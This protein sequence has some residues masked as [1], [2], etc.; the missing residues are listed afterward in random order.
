MLT[1]LGRADV[2]RLWVVFGVTAVFGVAAPV[3]AQQPAVETGSK[4]VLTNAAAI[5]E[6]SSEAAARHL[7]VRLCGVVLGI[8][9][10]G[11]DGYAIH[12]GTAGIY[13]QGPR[14]QVATLGH[15][16]L[17][18]V[19]GYTDPGEFAPFV[20]QESV[21]RLG[22]GE[23][24]EPARASFD[25]IISGRTD[26]Q[27]IEVTGV[28]RY[29]EPNPA[30]TNTCRLELT[31]GG[32]RLI[33]RLNVPEV[34]EPLVDAQVR[35]RGVCYYQVNKH[36]QVINAVLSVPREVPIIIEEPAP[37]DPFARPVQPINTLLQ[38][39][40]GGSYGH[41]VHVTGVV[42]CVHP[43]EFWIRDH[44][45]GLRVH[46]RSIKQIRIGDVVHVLGF[47][48]NGEYSPVLEDA[49]WK[50]VATGPEPEPHMLVEP[51]DAFD[52]DADLIALEAELVDYRPGPEGCVS[53]LRSGDSTF[54]AVLPG[55]PGAVA[56]GP[57][58]VP[59]SR[60]RVTGICSVVSDPLPSLT[61]LWRPR[62][63]Y[64][65]LRS[66][67]DMAV[68]RP[69]PLWSQR[70][71]LWLLGAATAASM[72]AVGLIWVRSRARLR[73]QAMNRAL[74]EAQFAAVLNERDRIARE[75]HDILAQGLSAIVLHLDLV[76][77]ELGRLSDRAARNLELAYQLA[78][79]AMADARNAVWNMRSQV[80]EQGDLVEALRGVLEQMTEGT[81]IA[82]ELRV[83][84]D[85]RRLPPII[86]NALLRIGQEAITNA[87]KHARPTRLVLAME[88]APRHVRLEVIDD[89]CGFDP[90]TVSKNRSG[91]GL[92]GMAGRVRALGGVFK[93][94]SSPGCGTRVEVTIPVPMQSA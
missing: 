94:D 55:W 15:G 66:P 26:A 91:F 24:P 37:A 12:D 69:P 59:G 88:F 7:P 32:G 63:F 27:W 36:R 39:A 40:A 84:G 62:S 48:K 20:I 44:T 10:I 85:S 16:D 2:L 72:F 51:G 90:A 87:V 76:K 89:G 42:T 78:R 21:T 3:P 75:L 70:R 77:D 74:A 49:I 67:G 92:E 50:V 83:A 17:V 13:I 73:E 35:L 80:L 11:S 68:L 64:L 82:T 19:T 43:G 25:E 28:V 56:A 52:Y 23:V 65:V 1:G 38:F 5:R 61:G 86:E 22:M 41:M 8:A 47:P 57:K 45:R 60:V 54:R 4:P 81:G 31:T 18:E 6:L 58:W 29:Y 93:L 53:V 79:T 9:E 30:N 33:A 46:T 14:E 34:R 71:V